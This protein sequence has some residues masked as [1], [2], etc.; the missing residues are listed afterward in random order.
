MSICYTDRIGSAFAGNHEVGVSIEASCS[1]INALFKI[2]SDFLNIP[3]KNIVSIDG[4]IELFNLYLQ[5][6]F[7]KNEDPP[8]QESDT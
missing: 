3:D 8:R 6:E 7:R 4:L 1:S 2:V 5:V